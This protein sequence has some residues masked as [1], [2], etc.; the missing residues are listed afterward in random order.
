MHN[1]DELHPQEEQNFPYEPPYKPDS[2]DVPE[3]QYWPLAATFWIDVLVIGALVVVV[4]IVAGVF[5]FV[6]I[7]QA[8]V[9]LFDSAGNVDIPQ[10]LEL[11]GTGAF[12]LL[13]LIQFLIFALVPIARITL[14]RRQSLAVIG[15]T[16]SRPLWLI[17]QGVGIGV[18]MLLINA[19]ISSFFVA[20]GISQNQLEQLPL[21]QGDY[22]GQ[23]L[24]A[25]LVVVAAPISEE[26]LFR[27]YA[28]SAFLKQ[29][30]APAA[31]L[32]SSLLFSI[33]H[34]LSVTQGLLA[35]LIPIFIMGLILAFIMHRT[36]SILPCII[37]HAFNNGVAI[38]HAITCINNPNA[39]LCQ[40]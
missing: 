35:L 28:F 32:I 17:V 4:N 30:G 9:P 19:L 37:A 25:L 1:I 27:G 21:F 6:R 15:F 20:Q 36:R 26:I 18:L 39:P 3:R 23:F 2:A 31:Y 5:L 24:V 29:W 11:M 33:A 38:S 14:L 22:I 40:S 10:L 12:S 13:L 7:S 8:R 34:S 16:A